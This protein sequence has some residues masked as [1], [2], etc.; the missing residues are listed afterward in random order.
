MT[1]NY[2]R[3]VQD[4]LERLYAGLTKDLADFL[5]AKQ[6]GS[7]FVFE[8]FGETGE[9]APDGITLGGGPPLSVLGILISLYALHACPDKCVLLPFKAFKEFP[10]AAPYV[11]AFATHTEQLL[12]PHV[13]K[14]GSAIPEIIRVLSGEEDKSADGGD[15]SFIVYPFPK[16]ALRY[17]FYEADEEFPASVTCLFS[18]NANRFLPMDGLADVGEYTSK[19]ILTLVK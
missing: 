19:K 7:R 13:D 15:F 3:I 16:I 6:S 1:D 12:V 11:G 17:I 9:I 10:D 14:I 2:A 8:A 5:P 18:S 4:N